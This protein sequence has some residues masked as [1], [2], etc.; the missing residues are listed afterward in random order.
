MKLNVPLV[1]QPLNSVD[2][3]IA[4]LA[5][6]FAYY[7]VNKSFTAIKKEI[8]VD[9]I[10]TYMPQIGNATISNINST[11]SVEWIC[12]AAPA[13]GVAASTSIP[14]EFLPAVCR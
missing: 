2:C 10:G 14:N 12:S 8:E 11:G 7:G 13:V 6:I 4:G 3:G 9:K 5:M 1:R